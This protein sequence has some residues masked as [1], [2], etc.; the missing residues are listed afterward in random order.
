MYEVT[1]KNP[2]LCFKNRS[3]QK[4]SLRTVAIH[5][6]KSFLETLK[7]YLAWIIDFENSILMIFDPTCA[8]NSASEIKV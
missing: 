2:S 3:V 7:Q 4:M 1:S 5:F 6:T 8:S